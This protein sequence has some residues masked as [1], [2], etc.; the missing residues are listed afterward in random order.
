MGR[1]ETFQRRR[2]QRHIE[3]LNQNGFDYISGGK[4]NQQMMTIKCRYCGTIKQ[5]QGDWV[6][7]Y[8]SKVHCKVCEIFEADLRREKKRIAKHEEAQRKIAIGKIR[9]RI[10]ALIRLKTPKEV[11]ERTV[12]V[13]V[14]GEC[15]KEYQ[16]YKER[17]MCP[18][19][20][21]RKAN[22]NHWHNRRAT[23]MNAMVDKD[24]DIRKVY[25]KDNGICYLC[26]CKCDWDDYVMD[27][28]TFIRGANYPSI[29]HVVPLAK[30]GKHSWQNVR[31]AHRKCNWEK[32]AKTIPPLGV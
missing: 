10:K 20:Y 25:E 17:V 31:L 23:I 14:C 5:V 32:S 11:K 13:F 27:G 26:N 4:D 2:L 19:C 18:D 16:S 7:R 30:G 15:G 8:N 28:D 22:S 6:G 1:V 12:N 3:K 24:I 9:T 21:K 29:D